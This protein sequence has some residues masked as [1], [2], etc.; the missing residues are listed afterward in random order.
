MPRYRYQPYE[1]ATVTKLLKCNVDQCGACFRHES[2]LRIHQIKE[3]HQYKTRPIA[4]VKP[5]IPSVPILTRTLKVNLKDILA[6]GNYALAEHDRFICP[7]CDK[8]T[9]AKAMYAHLFENHK[10]LL[11]LVKPKIK[12]ADCE[13]FVHPNSIT[14]HKSSKLCNGGEVLSLCY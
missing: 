6:K 11:K 7:V 14:Q 9:T 4:V 2:V 1:H 13:T 12:C 8:S 5:L 3:H 10:E